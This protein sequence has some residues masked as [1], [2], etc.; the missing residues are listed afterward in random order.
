MGS[1]DGRT[2]LVAGASR[3]IGEYM[4]KALAAAGAKVVVAARTVE[5]TDK[6]LPGTIHSVAQSINESGGKA[7]PV[8]MNM[9]DPESISAGVAEAAEKCGGLDIV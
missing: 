4:A 9:R 2:A 1:L 3:G 6:R 5:V 8:V 7:I